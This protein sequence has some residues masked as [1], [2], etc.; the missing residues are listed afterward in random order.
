[1]TPCGFVEEI[2]I[3]TYNIAEVLCHAFMPIEV[4]RSDPPGSGAN[5]NFC[6]KPVRKR[7]PLRCRQVV[8]RIPLVRAK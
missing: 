3:S 6:N 1:M 8:E 7:E 2:G 5:E 4:V